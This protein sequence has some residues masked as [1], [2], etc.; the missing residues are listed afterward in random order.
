M[1]M[2]ASHLVLLLSI[3][4]LGCTPKENP[5]APR[6]EVP[7]AI[8]SV[9][10]PEQQSSNLPS[11]KATDANPAHPA[12]AV[13]TA[14]NAALNNHQPE[15]LG[16]LYAPEVLFYGQRKPAGEIIQTKRKTLARSPGYRQRIENVRIEEGPNGFIVHFRKLS[17][18]A[19]L[20]TVQA[21]LVLERNKDGLFVVEETDAA[22]DERLTRP[23]PLTCADAALDALSEHPIIRED[24]KRVATE[25]PDVHPGG[26][27]YQ[28][29]PAHVEAAFGYM[30]PPRFESRWWIEIT[31]GKIK[32]YDKLTLDQLHFTPKQMDRVRRVCVVEATTGD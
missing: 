13:L 1:L 15:A 22:T 28:D 26:V 29:D 2:S 7:A 4:A 23:L 16:L 31:R 11:A 25:F 19:A 30:H 20:T 24:I 27:V 10:E 9:L 17:G 21:R 14:W 6:D 12:E 32:A 3:S 18:D 8:V 5:P